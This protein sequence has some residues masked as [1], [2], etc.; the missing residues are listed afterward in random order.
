[1]RIY[2]DHGRQ[3]PP[4]GP[5]T[6][7]LALAQFPHDIQAIRVCAER[8]HADIVSWNTYDRGGQYAAH[9]APDLLVQ[10]IRGFFA[11]RS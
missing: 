2:A 4:A 7:P 3:R 5:T 11:G 1:M 9:E 10:D 8:E 6:V